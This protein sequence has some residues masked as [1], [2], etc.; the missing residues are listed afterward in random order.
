MQQ[1]HLLKTE[2]VLT[3]SRMALLDAFE[4]SLVRKMQRHGGHKTTQRRSQTG[5]PKSQRRPWPCWKH[6]KLWYPFK[7]RNLHL[8][9]CNEILLPSSLYL[10][11][12][13]AFH[14]VPS[15]WPRAT[16]ISGS[17]ACSSK[18]GDPKNVSCQCLASPLMGGRTHDNS[19]HQETFVAHRLTVA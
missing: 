3:P 11:A 2:L 1:V 13:G 18:S 15:A 5:H 16:T 12:T 7:T 6:T 9:S 8:P 19:E 17:L 14:W 10:S 4:P